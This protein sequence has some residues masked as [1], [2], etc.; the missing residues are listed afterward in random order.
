[1]EIEKSWRA[2][3]ATFS[4][5]A[6]GSG[7]TMA[8]T[9]HALA[10]SG[11]EPAA[12]GSRHCT[13]RPSPSCYTRPA[14]VGPSCYA[15]FLGLIPWNVPLLANHAH[16]CLHPVAPCDQPHPRSLPSYRSGEA[17]FPCPARAS[18]DGSRCGRF[19]FRLENAAAPAPQIVG[20]GL[21]GVPGGAND[22]PAGW[23]AAEQWYESS[24]NRRW[25]SPPWK[26]KL[27]TRQD[28]VC[29]LPPENANLT[30]G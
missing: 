2:W 23:H 5:R 30:S 22:R 26:W 29:T 14:A 17:P 27:C 9:H 1:M 8:G 15:A 13:P 3:R 10:A 28:R 21:L 24:R 25:R 7:A 19:R 11:G 6:K 4:T 16:R 20:S 18:P 12:R